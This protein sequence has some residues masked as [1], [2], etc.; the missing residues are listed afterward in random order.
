MKNKSQSCFFLSLLSL[1]FFYKSNA[2]TL[3]DYETQIRDLAG[4]GNSYFA[5]YT[6]LFSSNFGFSLN[7]GWPGGKIPEKAGH[8]SISLVGTSSLIPIDNNNRFIE[9]N[10]L[11]QTSG[12]QVAP[13]TPG[14]F[15]DAEGGV[16][17]FF[18]LDPST[19]NRLVDPRDGAYIS[20]D[21]NML[22][23]LGTR[24]GVTPFIIPQIGLSLGRRTEVML[25]V[26]PFNINFDDGDMRVSALGGAIR[27]DLSQW[28][29]TEEDPA[30][31]VQLLLSYMQN[32][33]HFK[34]NGDQF[35]TFSNAFFNTAGTNI[36]L[37]HQ[38]HT[39]QAL[40]FFNYRLSKIVELYV[41]G[42][43]VHQKSDLGS[44]GLFQFTID[45]QYINEVLTEEQ[46][47]LTVSDVFH[48]RLEKTVPTG[49]AGIQFS[50]GSFQAEAQYS[51]ANTHIGSLGLRVNLFK[52]E[53]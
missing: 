22:K 51:Y 5:A 1:L 24:F 42:G 23:G 30:F 52:N 9:T 34:P 47:S 6:N 13:L 32:E 38:T 28:F 17:H 7:Q 12:I 2:Q 49:G 4:F 31:S 43:A 46:S 11:Y 48:S 25:R 33:V 50:F 20:A 26:L 21:F 15:T 45:N 27:H 40:L 14:I 35:L 3:Q 16:A 44:D 10:E 36:E 41:H 8:I 29:T 53:M 39:Q 18:L 19:N 37:S